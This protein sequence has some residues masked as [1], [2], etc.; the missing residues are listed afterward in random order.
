MGTA[1]DKNTDTDTDTHMDMLLVRIIIGKVLDPERLKDILRNVPVKQNDSAWNC[2]CWVR[3]ALV[4]VWAT[5][6]EGGQDVL[7][8]S[9]SCLQEWSTVR[10]AAMRY[11][12]GKKAQHRFDGKERVGQFDTRRTATLDL[13]LG[14]EVVP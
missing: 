8:A 13:L 10:D 9:S 6:A 2:V 1:T 12:E 7:G 5:T 3:D 11:V 4:R 14:K